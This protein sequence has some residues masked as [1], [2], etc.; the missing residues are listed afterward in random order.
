MEKTNFKNLKLMWVLKGLLTSYIVTALMLIGIS[1]LLYK[2]DVGEEFVR[3]GILVTYVISAFTG[4]FILGKLMKEK[5]YLWGFLMGCIYFLVLLVISAGVYRIIPEASDMA[6]GILL[7]AA[8][9]T[10]G[11]MIS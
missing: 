6:K 3:T 4:G 9:G 1:F 10:V 2:F 11:G 7:C 8:G 5:R